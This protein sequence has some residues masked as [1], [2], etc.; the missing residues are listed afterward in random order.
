MFFI[1]NAIDGYRKVFCYKGVADRKSYFF[2]VLFQ[3]PIAALI[4]WASIYLESISQGLNEET[5][6]SHLSI[7]LLFSLAQLAAYIYTFLASLAC[8]VRRLH[9]IGLSGWFILP[10]LVIAVIGSNVI[11]SD[12]FW[13]G[14]VAGVCVDLLF[15]L[16]KS[17]IENNKYRPA[18]SVPIPATDESVS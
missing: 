13:L 6:I 12:W 9:G 18:N 11:E 2:F 4:L 7:I 10:P 15:A 1:T 17:K 8:S 5:P 16:P 14:F 3:T